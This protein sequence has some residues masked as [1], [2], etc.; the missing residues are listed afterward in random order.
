MS[1][2]SKRPLTLAP[3]PSEGERS[4]D[5]SVADRSQEP[6]LRARNCKLQICNFQFAIGPYRRC[7][8]L[9]GKEARLRSSTDPALRNRR[10]PTGQFSRPMNRHSGTPDSSGR[11][12]RCRS[13]GCRMNPAF[14]SF[15]GS[16]AQVAQQVRGV[17][18]RS[19]SERAGVRV[20][21]DRSLLA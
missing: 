8:R 20:G 11:N 15:S 1:M 2:F 5:A 19:E 18:S 4:H 12:E 17:L 21:F 13:F 9:M 10:E 7:H 6:A 14:R 16:G 3:S